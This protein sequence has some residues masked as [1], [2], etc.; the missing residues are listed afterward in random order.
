MRRKPFDKKGSWQPAASDRVCYIHF[1]DG[2]ET[3]E[4]ALPT[5]FLGYESK[6]KKS[7]KTLFRKP[8]E[9]KKVRKGDITPVT[10]TS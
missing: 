10:L 3:D 4:N 8:L 5:F 2:L 6:E 7:R 9:K 1:A